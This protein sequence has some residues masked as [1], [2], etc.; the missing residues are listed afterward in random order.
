MNRLKHDLGSWIDHVR[1]NLLPPLLRAW[2]MKESAHKDW[3]KYV[4]RMPKLTFA[5]LK[6]LWA[7]APDLPK[8]VWIHGKQ[9]DI[10]TGH[11]IE[12]GGMT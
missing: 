10:K 3:V 7:D 4:D 8:T 2:M 9:Y 11:E 5:D 1:P 12:Q 6:I